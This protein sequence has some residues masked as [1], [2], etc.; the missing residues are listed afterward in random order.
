MLRSGAVG[1]LVWQRARRS[2]STYRVH[3]IREIWGRGS[4]E[5]HEFTRARMAKGELPRV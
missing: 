2:R 5:G 3:R 1:A 4:F